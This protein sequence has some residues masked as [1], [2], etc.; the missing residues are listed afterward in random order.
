LSRKGGYRVLGLHK[1][2]IR[3]ALLASFPEHGKL[4]DQNIILFKRRN[5]GEVMDSRSFMASLNIKYGSK[6]DELKPYS[7]D[8]MQDDSK[9]LFQQLL[10]SK[11]TGPRIMERASFKRHEIIHSMLKNM[12]PNHPVLS[13]SQHPDIV[14]PYTKNRLKV[15]LDFF[16]PSLS[17][18]LEY[19]SETRFGFLKGLTGIS[20]TKIETVK[21]EGCLNHGIHLINIPYWWNGKMESLVA[22]IASKRPDIFG[23]VPFEPIPLRPSQKRPEKEKELYYSQEAEL[24]E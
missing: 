2:N 24:W 9:G 13:H 5:K 11:T 21:K 22:T 18:A 3:K 23:S 14:I 7:W 15:E 8:Y 16:I 1:S 6:L 10:H 17:L 19:S 4:F 12:I 20:R